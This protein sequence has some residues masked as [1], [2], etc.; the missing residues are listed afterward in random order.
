MFLCYYE[1]WGKLARNQDDKKHEVGVKVKTLLLSLWNPAMPLP[2][3]EN[4]NG[5]VKKDTKTQ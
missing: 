1:L 5:T 3:N 2:H 4:W